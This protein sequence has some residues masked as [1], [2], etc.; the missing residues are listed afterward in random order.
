MRTIGVI[1][2]ITALAAVVFSPLPAAAFGIHLGPLH[3]GFGGH[4]HHHHHLHMRTNPNEARTRPNDVSR[5]SS[6]STA[7]RGDNAAKTDQTD[8]E[9]RAETNSEALESCAGLAQGVTNLPI[10]QIRQ[11]VHPTADQEAALDDLSATSALASD[12][13]KSCPASAPL[14]PVGR[15]DAA[16]QRLSATIKA[17]HILRSPLERFYRSLSDEQRRQFNA[18]NGSTESAR[19]AGNMAALC[20]QQAGVINLPVQRIEQV[21]Q[22][23]AQQQSTFDVLKKAAQKAGDDLQSSCPTAV[24][25]SPV[26]QLDTVATRLGIMVDAIEAVRPNLKNFY[27]S[28]SDEQKERFNLM[29]SPPKSAPS[30]SER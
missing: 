7:T 17:I 12:I 10:D 14:T 6:Y 28:L 9:T 22:P 23:T 8:R 5:S 30:P 27:A 1:F 24:P 4:H 21:V 29:G 20:S 15:L 18:M 2:G 3:F 13:I 25:K 16:E 26:A 11:T 19:S